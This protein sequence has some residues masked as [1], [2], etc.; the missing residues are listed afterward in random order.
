[1]ALVLILDHEIE[2]LQLQELT[3]IHRTL[4]TMFR[5]LPMCYTVFCPPTTENLNECKDLS[6]KEEWMTILTNNHPELEEM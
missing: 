1:M 3:H 6:I 5:I 2:E 4:K